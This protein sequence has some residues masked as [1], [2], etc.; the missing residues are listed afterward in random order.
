LAFDAIS[1]HLIWPANVCSTVA[2]I[3]AAHLLGSIPRR[4]HY[5]SLETAWQTPQETLRKMGRRRS[6]S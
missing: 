3:W 5:T 1:S 6:T 4:Y 2:A